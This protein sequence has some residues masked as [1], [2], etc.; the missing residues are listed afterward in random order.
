M[1]SALKNAA[2]VLAAACLAMAVMAPVQ[3]F[4][5]EAPQSSGGAPATVTLTRLSES[6][7]GVSVSVVGDISSVFP[8][9]G[10]FGY[11]YLDGYP[12]PPSGTQIID[13]QYAYAISGGNFREFTAATA[14]ESFTATLTLNG[15]ERWVLIC[16]YSN[17]YL[18]SAWWDSYEIPAWTQDDADPAV[19]TPGR[20]EATY[21]ISSAADYV[22]RIDKDFSLYD[23]A[24]GVT[25]DGTALDAANYTVAEGSTVVTIKSAYLDTLSVGTHTVAV[26]FTDGATV[27]HS[28]KVLAAGTGVPATGDNTAAIAITASIIAL[29]GAALLAVTLRK[30]SRS[31]S[32]S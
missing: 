6:E 31:R 23:S 5:L 10:H 11:T 17:E 24:A 21:V 27:S 30:R 3:A 1:K 9:G 25:I 28:I 32:A 18:Q 20:S 19:T 8:Q 16:L 12:G 7:L 26:R 15:L 4:A 22:L 14:N 29:F 2:R 13:G